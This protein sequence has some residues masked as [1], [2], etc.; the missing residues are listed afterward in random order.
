M[1]G[2]I[3]P[4][5]NCIE[6]FRA[7]PEDC[8]DVLCS[9][10]RE[11]ILETVS[12]NGGHLASSLGAVEL[13]VA[14]HRVYD[15]DND[16][17]IFDVGHQAY[18]H[19]IIT[20]RLDDFKTLRKEN[21]ISGFPKREESPYDV[22]N[23]GHASTSVSAALG[24]VRAKK[25]MGEPGN[26]AC[27]IGDGALTGGLAYEGLDDAGDSGLP[28]V[29]ILND[30][31]MSIN[32]NVGALS[33]SL[34]HLRL[35]YGYNNFKKN[36]AA[37]LDRIDSGKKLSFR[38]SSFKN[39]IKRFIIRNT[40][41][42]ELGFTYL[43]LI[44]GHNVHELIRILY[45]AKNIG[46]P[47]VVH[48]VTKKG[49]GYSFSEQHPERFHGVAPFIIET[50]ELKQIPQRDCS[51]VFAEALCEYAQKDKRITAITAAMPEGTGLNMFFE[52]YPDRFFDTGIAEEHALTMAAGMA[53]G[54]LRPVIAIYSSFV[55]RATDQLFHDVCLQNLPV[56][57]A[58]DR[59]GLVGRDGETHNGLMDYSLFEDMPN[60]EIYA[61]DSFSALRNALAY[62]LK[63]NGPSVIRYNRGSLP[64]GTEDS[65]S[66][67]W[68]TVLPVET[69][70]VVTYG[71]ILEECKSAVMGL[72]SKCG[73]V[74]AISLKPVD[75]GML[76]RMEEKSV[77]LLIVEEG[78]PVL[79]RK[80]ALDYPGIR[81]ESVHIMSTAVAQGSVEEQRRRNGLDSDSLRIKIAKWL[82]EE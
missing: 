13:I 17:L 15:S 6:D 77:S 66:A 19:K 65:F 42:E 67:R 79:A 11:C 41:F 51:H 26:V 54:G 28:L 40:F 34:S 9:E 55:Q 29:V 21:G 33:K 69:H 10:I 56:V 71:A 20:G 78:P 5:I 1:K 80:I 82:E 46:R 25:L 8:L 48:T 62:S 24:M 30:N 18:T 27:L 59:A 32:R 81:L 52:K 60:L 45:E 2:K 35:S 23:T 16:R 50:G 57:L 44:D 47:V 43:G 70:T 36:T 4:K 74:S 64:E 73:L 75:E 61:P 22:F 38:V 14:M 72:K 63:R 31:E 58:V 76:T 3:L 68:R 7:L 53:A 49:K 12:Q 39:R 37:F